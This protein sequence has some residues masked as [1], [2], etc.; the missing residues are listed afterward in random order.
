MRGVNIS[1]QIDTSDWA[2]AKDPSASLEI[3]TSTWKP[4]GVAN[5]YNPN[6]EQFLPTGDIE[7]KVRGILKEV[8][9]S[10]SEKEY[11]VDMA[12]KGASKQEISDAILTIQGIHPKQNLDTQ[13]TL[14]KV[15]EGVQDYLKLSV[16]PAEVLYETV[17]K[18]KTP[19]S[20]YLEE[21]GKGYSVPKPLSKGEKS[22][23]G[24]KINSIWGTPTES[25]D[26][27]RVTD[28]GKKLFNILPHVKESGNDL[29]QVVYGAATGEELPW[30]QRLKNEN[31]KL[32]FETSSKYNKNVLD[33]SKIN[34]FEDLNPTSDAYDFSLSTIANTAVNLGAYVLEQ[35][36]TRGSLG[37][38]GKG[39]NAALRAGKITEEAAQ[40][41]I[42]AES[43]AKGFTASYLTNLGEAMEAANEKGITG[44]GAYLTALAATAPIAA[45]DMLGGGYGQINKAFEKEAGQSLIKKL[46]Q[47]AIE[48]ADGN[49]TKEVLDDLYKTSNLAAA[50][51]AE[52]TPKNIL[53]TA[54]EESAQE[55][56]QNVIQKASQVIHDN[57]V[58]DGDPK[59][60]TELFSPQSIGDYINDAFGGLIGGAQGHVLG[61]VLEDKNKNEEKSKTIMSA[62][63]QG[64]ENEL[65][66]E[67]YG[68]FKA[69]N[70]TKEDLD[71]ALFKI[72]KYSE[73]HESTK[74]RNLDDDNKRRIFDLTYE[75][76]NIQ[77]GLD[78][79]EESNPDGINDGEIGYRK[80]LIKEIEGEVKEI[81][82]GTEKKE[83]PKKEPIKK[84]F[85]DFK[86]KPVKE[87]P[88]PEFNVSEMSPEEFENLDPVDKFHAIWQATTDKGKFFKP[89]ELN[90]TLEIPIG[91]S[92]KINVD[93]KLID[94]A[95]SDQEREVVRD[96]EKTFP[97][98]VL[99]SYEGE[100]VSIRPSKVG[101]LKALAVY[102]KEGHPIKDLDGQPYFIRVSEKGYGRPKYN[103]EEFI[104]PD[105]VEEHRKGSEG[106]I[107]VPDFETR[108]LGREFE[109]EIETP[110]AKEI[111]KKSI[112][113]PHTS[114]KHGEKY[115]DF[116]QRTIG[117]Y[118]NWLKKAKDKSVIVTHSQVISLINQW[119]KQGRPENLNEL[120]FK[121]L[122]EDKVGKDEVYEHT[123]DNGKVYLVR[124]GETT[125]NGPPGQSKF[126]SR[127]VSLNQSGEQTAVEL[128]EKL[129]AKGVTDIITSPLKRAKE[130][131]NIIKGVVRGE[132]GAKPVEPKGP[133]ET[134]VVD[135]P[136]KKKVASK[137]KEKIKGDEPKG[138]E[139]KLQKPQ[140]ETREKANPESV[141]EVVKYLK[142]ANPKLSIEYDENL[143][144]AGSA[145]GNQ[146]K[147]NPFYAGIDTPIHEAGHIFID[148]IGGLENKV[149]KKAVDQLRNT[150]LWN[151][152][153][154]RYPELSPDMLA[155][156][157]LAEAIGRE[158]AGIFKKA[159]ETS[160]FKQLLD[161][162]FDRI[163][164]VFGFNRNIAK[165]LAKKVLLGDVYKKEKQPETTSLQKI[166]EEKKYFGKAKVLPKSY[167]SK[168]QYGLSTKELE[169]RKRD[170][171]EKILE[172]S[173]E[174]KPN[175][176]SQLE[177]LVD[178]MK[179]I[180]DAYEEY[181]D[182]VTNIKKMLDEDRDF[183]EL[184]EDELLEM[185]SYIMQFDDTAQSSYFKDIMYRIA[186]ALVEK[187]NRL[188]ESKGV[189]IGQH[190]FRD[191]NARGVLFKSLSHI[192]EY[193]PELQ[194]LSKIWDNAYEGYVSE[195]EK[196][197]AEITNL[198]KEVIK[199]EKKKEGV[200][201]K[202]KD[203]LSP[204]NAKYFGWM[205]DG[206]E[207]LTTEKA[208]SKG[209]SDAKIKYLEKYRQIRDSFK[210][211]QSKFANSLEDNALVKTGR[212]FRETLGD[213]GVIAAIQQWLSP[214]SK[215]GEIKMYYEGT[216]KQ[217]LKTLNEINLD[218]QEQAK[219]GIISKVIAGSKSLYYAIKAQKLLAKKI[220]EDGSKL[221]ESFYRTYTINQQGQIVNKFGS[222]LEGKYS[223]DFHGAMLQYINEMSFSK[224]VNPVLPYVYSVEYYNANKFG[225][226]E[227]KPNVT[228]FIQLWRDK[229]IFREKKTLLPE[230][231][232][233]MRFLRHLTSMI[234]MTFNL[235]AGLWNAVMGKYNAWRE[236]GLKAIGRGEKRFFK[237]NNK[238]GK[239]FISSKARNILNK[240]NIVQT[241]NTT[242]LKP[243]VGKLWDG[244]ATM[245]T[246]MGEFYV[247]GTMFLGQI[248]NEDYAKIDAEGNYTG[249]DKEAFETRMKQYRK[250]VSDI[251]GK[252]S[253]KDRR[254]FELWELGRFVGQFRTWVPDWWKERFG[255]KYYTADGEVHYGS[256][257]AF[258]GQSFKELYTAVKSRK[259]F[260]SEEYVYK[261]MRQNLRGAM[262]TAV[263]LAASLSGDDDEKKRKKGND[264]ADATQNLLFVFD[265][266]AL[267][268][269]LSTPAPGLKAANDFYKAFAS[270]FD[271]KEGTKFSKIIPYKNLIDN[272]YVSGEE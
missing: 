50:T 140:K 13:T 185:Y 27:S 2:P 162:I 242:D 26:D 151:E 247:Q 34:S 229:H 69:G 76:A 191:L 190:K 201:D 226:K 233:P 6:N 202:V 133:V 41:A 77:A 38:A 260:T 264:L 61:K 171:E 209:L 62:I 249:E 68:A 22:P 88:V 203:F 257:R 142:K 235:K 105:Y 238:T 59:Y 134:P 122:A 144:A 211:E 270:A 267:K 107:L 258:A 194:Q 53:R 100:P 218:L 67:L 14:D 197:N 251:Q 97:N 189:E 187:Q 44:R 253:E 225:D 245:L 217:H 188:L 99:L 75:K 173:N 177:S 42:K 70:I 60:G 128:G 163:K 195:R 109:G 113:N 271:A 95:S 24:S 156:E 236:L 37:T 64:N 261:R 180:D 152:T 120:D 259:M 112:R 90:G 71:K 272:E 252:Y 57:L 110:E 154:E 17:A 220:N 15:T 1:K 81:W 7:E 8:N 51:V 210:G 212:N 227:V 147:I 208:R 204:N 48:D 108:N 54:A 102:D 164:A 213:S 216:G 175:M 74:D 85:K 92:A 52:K 20:Y 215:T 161:Y 103:S 106:L 9:S 126:R 19:A 160:K 199:E 40:K 18:L 169:A 31:E 231:D 137:A 159:S 244:M 214:N 10:D 101:Q 221:P 66:T 86:A 94:L 265:P 230:I 268:Y 153:Q 46:V 138:D 56:S 29:A 239:Y 121:K 183:Y 3:D 83:E 266:S 16:A 65:K 28:I 205:D 125:E 35:A 111:L 25:E 232:I 79:L 219:K 23:V 234:S 170:L 32:E 172:A 263:V 132:E 93:G 174:E 139:P 131:A 98:K 143:K 237:L 168:R 135:K 246:K 49:V 89:K 196:L 150:G 30:Y 145:K 149:I 198:A 43:L 78:K 129:K 127:Q 5:I 55:L 58:D 36:L 178:Q 33:V 200:S 158:G 179:V 11:I 181:K 223:K 250:K 146:I 39:A 228:K 182:S 124:H 186:K 91:R 114:W 73:Y 255:E 224:N 116:A 136:T 184:S 176:K 63:A 157:V 80:D 123:S 193:F 206:G 165:T 141:N 47:G 155:K 96:G 21:T 166:K 167:F 148:S 256:Y 104:H 248:S 269:M 130:T 240:Y 254:N 119:E 4:A 192:Q 84:A 262:V 243:Y 87:G 45:I 115:I 207:L 222:P 72:D 82:Q 117:A 241:E 12:M 118:K